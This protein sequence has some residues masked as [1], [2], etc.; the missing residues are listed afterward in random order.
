MKQ[1]DPDDYLQIATLE[2]WAEDDTIEG[3]SIR[4]EE[5][6]IQNIKLQVTKITSSN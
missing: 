1:R 4:E 2:G 3:H 5:P 6:L